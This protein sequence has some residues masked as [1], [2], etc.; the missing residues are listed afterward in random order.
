MHRCQ[1]A[2]LTEKV[3]WKIAKSGLQV[4]TAFSEI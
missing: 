1:D 3:E 2:I 4:Q